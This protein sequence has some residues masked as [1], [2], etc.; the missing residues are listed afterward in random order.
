MIRAAPPGPAARLKNEAN[1]ADLHQR[2]WQIQS[3]L[4]PDELATLASRHGLRLIENRLLSPY[5]RLRAIHELPARLLSR[6]FSPF[7]NLHPIVP[8]MLGSR[9]LQKCLRDGSLEYRLL[10]FERV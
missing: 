6:L 5:L 2:G 9:A 4:A 1:L 7:W 8:S 10:V 3:L